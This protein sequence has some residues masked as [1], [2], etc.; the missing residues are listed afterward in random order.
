M[1][2]SRIIEIK[3]VFID[4]DYFRDVLDEVAEC[5]FLHINLLSLM[6]TDF[7]QIRNIKHKKLLMADLFLIQAYVSRMTEVNPNNSKPF[8]EFQ[9]Q[10]Q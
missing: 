1:K 3:T 5:L 4:Q 7:A 9:K 6:M 10:F 8:L 2:K